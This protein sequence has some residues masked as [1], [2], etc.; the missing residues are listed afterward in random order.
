MTAKTFVKNSVR[1][2]RAKIAVLLVLPFAAL[3]SLVIAAGSGQVSPAPITAKEHRVAVSPIKLQSSYQQ[4]SVA[5]GR[6]EANQQASL[7][8]ELA[9]TLASTAVDEGESVKQGDVLAQLDLARLNARMQE[10]DSALARA[11]ADARLAKLSEQRVAELVNKKLESPQRLD[12]TR[13]ATKAADAAVNE[14]E[15]Q[16]ISLQVEVQKSSILAPFDGVVVSR[17]VD[18]GT[19]VNAGQSIFSMQK[20]GEFDA[21]MALTPKQASNLAVGQVYQLYAGDIGYSARIKSIAGQRRLDTRTVDVIFTLTD[22]NELLPGDLV[23]LNI[24]KSV[25][26]TGAWVPKQAL[27][28]GVRGLWTLYTASGQA[29]RHKVVAKAVEAIYLQGE[30][31]Y[32]S[33]ALNDG[34]LLIV[35]GTQRL[36]P[37]QLVKVVNADTQLVRR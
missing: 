35:N 13:E 9:G 7:G 6:V 15:A 1:P 4:F 25:G 3:V 11:K 16:Q 8:F 21:R 36:V 20:R 5:T 14:I 24:T 33:G 12:E 27:S 19:V 34:E 23:S 18:A 37:E 10:L 32:V 2:S 30:R 17:F 22:E 29:E 26:V 31:A 28:G